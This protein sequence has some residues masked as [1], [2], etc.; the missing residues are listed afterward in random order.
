MLNRQKFVLN[1]DNRN[2]MHNKKIGGILALGW[3]LLAIA[4][5]GWASN[6]LPVVGLWLAGLAGAGWIVCEATR[7]DNAYRTQMHRVESEMRRTLDRLPVGV[8]RIEA[9][10]SFIKT[11]DTLVNMLHYPTAEALRATNFF[12][13]F[14]QDDRRLQWQ[15]QLREAGS[16]HKVEIELLQADGTPMCGLVSAIIERGKNDADEYID[17]VLEDISTFQHTITEIKQLKEFHEEIVQSISEGIV[18]ENTVG[19]I[20][21]VNPAAADMLGYTPQELVGQL[22]NVIIPAD[23]Q[24]IIAQADERRKQGVAD[25][26]EMDLLRKDG[27]RVTVLVSGSPRIENGEFVGSLAVLTNI[28]AQKDAEAALENVN[29][30][31]EY[32]VLRANEL[33]VAAEGANQAK[34]E[35]LA[36][37]SHEIRTPMNGIIGMTEL[38][39]DTE[40]SSE[41]REYLTAVQ[42]SAEALLGIINDVLD[43]SK[44]EAGKLELEEIEFNLRDVI[45]QLADILS[46]RAIQKHLELLISV[47]PAATTAVRGDPLRLRQILVNLV[48]NAVKFTDDGEVA[49]E[50]IEL[51]KDEDTVKFQMSVSDTGIGIPEHKQ[52]LIFENFS[53]ADSSTTRRFG[54]T[55][56]G[57]AISKQLVEMMGGRI[58]VESEAGHGSVFKFTVV[59]PRSVSTTPSFTGATAIEGRRV[60]VIDDNATSRRILTTMLAA[61]HCIFDEA[62]SGA[63][64]IA[65]L[66]HALDTGMMYDVVLLDTMM[67]YISGIDVLQT[68]RHIKGLTDVPVVMLTMV[69]TISM[70]TNRRDLRRTAYVTKPVKQAELL[71]AL[72]VAIGAAEAPV[73]ATT[74]AVPESTIDKGALRILL[75]EDNEINRRLATAMLEREGYHLHTAEN[76]KVALEMLEKHGFDLILMDVQMPEMDGL[77]AT[78]AIRANPIWQHIPIIAMTAHA[79]KGDKER[80]IAAGM[81]DYITKP[82][83]TPKVMAAI[84]RQ[85]ARTRQTSATIIADEPLAS[86]P[87]SLPVTDILDPSGPLDWLGG[88]VDAFTELLTFFLDEA[89]GYLDDLAAAIASG[90]TCTV[91]QI[92]HKM[93]GAAADM[94]AFQVQQSAFVLERMGEAA[95]LTDAQPALET[96]RAELSALLEHSKTLVTQPHPA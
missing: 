61:W 11:N 19:K 91:D 65:K 67:P 40:L 48:G 87:A 59:L 32:A 51:E 57:L 9:D 33:A 80:F 55:G 68:I 85:S 52:D 13:L 79:M 78:A 1:P 82:I 43:F 18:V 17:G 54:G 10:G 6:P 74:K 70:I 39:L 77:E 58:W 25:H 56:L 14:E 53:Q 69:N 35:F 81:D 92:A 8:F 46:Q 88:D 47:H 49:V 62:D 89:T 26:Y 94:G 5:A 66:Q 60:L 83:R 7:R 34:S 95:D 21:F 22:L 20:T 4:F 29:D 27:S 90:D 28:T 45:E 50:V 37:M 64:G 3:T 96:L 63:A 31:L 30:E 36:N 38:A 84:E 12:S 75:A 42:I 86:V 15:V 16:C 23:R 73:S 72:L 93:K 71:H 44:I 76:G 24:A 41:Q 2:V